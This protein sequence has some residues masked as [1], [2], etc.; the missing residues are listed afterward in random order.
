MVHW[1]PSQHRGYGTFNRTFELPFKVD[2]DKVEA[3]FS[4][5]ILYITLPRAEEDKPKK[6]SVKLN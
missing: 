5:G 4:K 2:A 1:R 3:K 6:I